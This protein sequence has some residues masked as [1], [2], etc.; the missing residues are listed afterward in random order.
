MSVYKKR[1]ADIHTLPCHSYTTCSTWAACW[2]SFTLWLL[3]CL[4]GRA[5]YVRLYKL[6]VT[7]VMMNI[8]V[9][10]SCWLN[11]AGGEQKKTGWRQYIWFRRQQRENQRCSLLDARAWEEKG[12]EQ[13]MVPSKAR[14]LMIDACSW[15]NTSTS[16]GESHRSSHQFT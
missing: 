1:S 2:Q 12:G 13:A 6:R 9:I 5:S 16:Y 8:S 3:S 7:R 4:W 10:I 14:M 15:L 11:T